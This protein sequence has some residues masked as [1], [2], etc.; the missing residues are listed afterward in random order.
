MNSSPEI[1]G[2][3]CYQAGFKLRYRIYF[4]RRSDAPL[5]WSVDEGSQETEIN[6]S[7]VEIL[8]PIKS[9]YNGKTPNPDSPVAWF[10]TDGILA[11]VNDV[12]FILKG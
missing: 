6:V 7:R 8:T 1:T 4:N 5:V 9:F 3:I 10:E 11:R 2:V 12:A